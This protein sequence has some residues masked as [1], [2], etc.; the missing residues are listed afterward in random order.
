[1]LLGAERWADRDALDRRLA[2]AVGASLFVHALT[3][4]SLHDFLPSLPALA[5][6][7]AGN[8]AALQAVLAGPPV[9]VETTS[10]KEPRAINPALLL[11]P[12]A[13]VA[14]RPAAPAPRRQSQPPPAGDASHAG[15]ASPKV[16]ITIAVVSDATRLGAVYAQ[17]LAERFPARASDTPMLGSLAPGVMYPKAA[18]DSGAE[19]RVLAV[20]ILDAGGKIVDA[21]LLPDDPVFGPAVL[22]WLKSAQFSPALSAGTPVPYW[23]I[24]EIVFS[25]ARPDPVVAAARPAARP[26][27]PRARQ[28]S[29][30]R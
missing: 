11:P 26:S 28:P 6:R 14:E 18:L 3:L 27:A 19:G 30:G 12:A 16:S 15:P 4:A 10:G 21:K 2:I 23:T 13:N 8:F 1:M 7:G 22:N 9:D 24:V 5:E 29:V 17:Q 25:I 20:L